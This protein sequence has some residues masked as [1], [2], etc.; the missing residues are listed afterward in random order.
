M[1][2][3]KDQNEQ[4]HELQD[5]GVAAAKELC[6]ILDSLNYDGQSTLL[7]PHLFSRPNFEL[8]YR[9]LIWFCHLLDPESE[10]SKLNSSSSITTTTNDASNDSNPTLTITNRSDQLAFLVQV[11]KLVHLKL[12]FRLNLVNLYR[13]D[14]VSCK[15]LLRIGR[16]II[17]AAKLIAGSSDNLAKQTTDDDDKLPITT[18]NNNKNKINQISSNNIKI[19]TRTTI[20]KDVN[21]ATETMEEIL[22]SLLR[23][24]LV[25][26]DQIGIKEKYEQ[27][28]SE[29]QLQQQM[30]GSSLA[31]TSK[32]TSISNDASEA[33]TQYSSHVVVDRNDNDDYHYYDYDHLVDEDNSKKNIEQTSGLLELEQVVNRSIKRI[34]LSLV[35]EEKHLHSYRLAVMDRP[36]ELDQI[37]GQLAK[38][39]EL[40]SKQIVELD[41]S[42]ENLLLDCRNLDEKLRKKE[43]ELDDTKEQLLALDPEAQSSKYKARYDELKKQY[44]FHY[45]DYVA[46]F[47]NLMYLRDCLYH[48][49]DVADDDDGGDN[50]ELDESDDEMDS[51]GDESIQVNR[52]TLNQALKPSEASASEA[53]AAKMESL[54]GLGAGAERGPGLTTVGPARLL[55]SLLE[56][57]SS[58]PMSA[59][60]MGGAGTA[61]AGA[62][63]N[64]AAGARTDGATTLLGG[65]LTRRGEAA[66]GRVAP[67]EGATG[68]A[69]PVLPKTTSPVDGLELE[70]LLNEFMLDSAAT[71]SAGADSVRFQAP[72]DPGEEFAE[73]EEEEDNEL[74]DD[75]DEEEDGYELSEDEG[76]NG[77]R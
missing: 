61:E 58:K 46:K 13:A 41:K 34:E 48:D 59:S 56:T 49:L 40:M 36:F 5:D 54:F 26:P 63:G 45:N 10:L 42:N 74:D 15:E 51:L 44:E 43:F 39:I 28:K 38:G 7:G 22:Y 55:E 12:G 52:M 67:E 70:G 1:M 23:K 60:E 24:K 77:L 33:N 25:L 69:G 30:D 37:R 29:V 72:S 71:D 75:E 18:R 64:T 20:T 21:D 4:V 19:P 50:G 35:D 53:D 8:V 11:G 2:I 47:K 17:D 62:A 76:A 6:Q 31:T 16:Y 66:I 32:I 57:G 65:R 27:G 3:N 73:P 68:A 9:I 14:L